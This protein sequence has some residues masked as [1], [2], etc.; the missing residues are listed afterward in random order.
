MPVILGGIYATLYHEHAADHSGADFVYK[1]CLASGFHFALHTFG[2][3]L[4][5]RRG[6]VASHTVTFYKKNPFV[7][8]VTATGCP[9]TCSYCASKVLSGT[10]QRRSPDDVVR[11]IQEFHDSGVADV[12]FYDDALLVDADHHIKPILRGVLKAGQNIRF[13]TPNGL[14]ARF[15]DEE[16][17]RLMKATGFKTIRLSLE[18]VDEER[19][20]ATG[21]KV[22]TDDLVRA[23]MHLR[24][25]G[26][27]KRDI[28]VYVMYGLPG[29]KLKEVKEGIRFLKG[30]DVRI[31]LTE[32]SPIR[33][34]QS[35][36]ELVESGIIYDDLDPL[37]TNN[38]VFSY[39][40]S[41]YDPMDIGKLK[42]DVKRYNAE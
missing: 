10:Y 34:T 39:L 38:T 35:W 23:V 29:Q 9:F 31:N 8:L 17:A 22:N 42:L 6:P 33:G 37:L 20:K 7:P 41:T 19:Q 13:H 15:M 36:N 28:G 21:G 16:L 25:Q 5:R 30:L 18:T 32:F 40:C 27:T 2:F 26:F 14:H 1:G 3:K 24:Q 12:A 4:K 11:E